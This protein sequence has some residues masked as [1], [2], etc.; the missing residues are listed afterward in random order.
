[1]ID[2]KV[3]FE[4]ILS[5]NQIK[6][7][8]PMAHHNTYGI[9]GKAD[10]FVTPTNK[11][12]LIGVLKKASLEGV[13]ITV[14]GGGSNCLISDK[15]IRGVTI[16]TSRMKPEM[17]CNDTWITAF[18]GV[19]T[20]TIS[21]FAQKNCL[22][23]FEWAVGIP[24]TLCGAVFMNANGYGS[25]MKK[26]VEEVYAVSIDG[27][28]E[29]TY[30]W[31]DL[32]YGESDSVFMHNGD[33]IIGV[34]LHLAHG[35]PEEIKE[36]MRDHQES[37]RMKQPLDKRSAGT[38]YLRPPGYHVGPMIKDCGLIGFA[39]GDAQ[40]STK[41][42]DFVVNNGNASCAEVLAVLHEVQ[43]RVKERFGVHV[44]LDVR[45]IGEG[46]EQER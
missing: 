31:D 38:M 35:D 36:A 45:L 15:G 29:K 37:R 1:M 25:K 17:T 23:G 26:V 14:I 19:G 13:P 30:G 3:F 40:V 18:G 44:P 20:G 34:K 24:G 41:H 8:E 5:E 43:R 39:I 16:C 21:R 32:H 7:D 10:A 28:I 42:P 12:E 46:L 6:I 11:E 4:G 9:G 22:K 27:S 33:I 2:W